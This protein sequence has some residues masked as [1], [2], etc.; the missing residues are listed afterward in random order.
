MSIFSVRTAVRECSRSD[1]S[2]IMGII[3]EK[4]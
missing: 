4:F 2:T 3:R 1:F